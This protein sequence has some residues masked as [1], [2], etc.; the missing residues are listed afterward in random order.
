MKVF[1]LVATSI[2]GLTGLLLLL[3]TLMDSRKI[4]LGEV[5]SRV[6]SLNNAFM[7]GLSTCMLFLTLIM[8][9]SFLEED[10]I[11]SFA[12]LLGSLTISILIGFIVFLSTLISFVV[13]GKYREILGKKIADK[14]NKTQ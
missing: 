2:I 7:T 1:L 14:I 13:V 8:I 6:S 5:N 9:V 3:K 11:L 4:Y 12:G 10:L